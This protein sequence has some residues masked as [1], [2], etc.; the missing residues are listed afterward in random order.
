MRIILLI[1]ILQIASYTKLIAQN[2]DLIKE[3]FEDNAL[4]W[5][6]G[7]RDF[8]NFSIFSGKYHFEHSRKVSGW[9]VTN[10]LP[11]EIPDNVSI[12]AKINKISGVG[13]GYGIIFGGADVSNI[14]TFVIS[15]NGYYRYAYY[16]NNK[17]IEVIKW[18]K[19]PYINGGNATNLIKVGI[20]GNSIKFYVNN[21][22]IS[23]APYSIRYGDKLGFIIYKD[24]KIEID[25]LQ[26]KGPQRILT[27]KP[28]KQALEVT[29][30][31][32]TEPKE[33]LPKAENRIA[34]VIGNSSYPNAPLKNPVNDALLVTSTLRN[35]GF[36]VLSITDASRSQIR[37]AIIEFGDKLVENKGVGLFYYAGHGIQANGVNYIVPVDAE[38]QRA[39]EI[40]DECIR[41]DRV[42]RMMSQFQNPLN[43]VIL[44]ACRNNP[45]T[46][47][48]RSLDRGLAQPQAA[49]RGSIVAF[50]T[51]PGMTASD[52]D[53]DNGLY[54]QE[55][56]KAMQKEGLTIEE[57][58]KQVRIN[59][60][61]I[62]GG[63]QIPWENS[64]LMGDFYFIRN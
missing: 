3:E 58:F 37:N 39:F 62:S 55:L 54:T 61:Q 16:N 52:G 43:I 34:L 57:V 25:Y 1:T 46:R 56:V 24:Q 23:Q 51:A 48:F 5:P 42:M 47:S 30:R 31:E 6:I 21:A 53:G 10:T 36:D 11:V 8:T 17:F 63:D 45:Y 33:S 40:E 49:A 19:S 20:E 14:H 32:V 29:K 26:I 4:N 18:T 59:V 13:A 44:D 41:T 2:T 27:N 22:L 28:T 12:E 50:A 7:S 38:I 35:L 60:S 9:L 15:S 64:S